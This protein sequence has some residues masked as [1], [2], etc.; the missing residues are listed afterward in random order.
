[1]KHVTLVDVVDG[2]S[3]NSQLTVGQLLQASNNILYYEEQ[4]VILAS[5][6]K[7]AKMLDK[8]T[9]FKYAKKV[10][11]LILT[12]KK[13]R[14]VAQGLIKHLVEEGQKNIVPNQASVFSTYCKATLEIANEKHNLFSELRKLKTEFINSKK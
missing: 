10:K 5:E 7:E 13:H 9:N 8:A 3:N 6:I 2:E 1:M 4:I 11:D 12:I 14:T